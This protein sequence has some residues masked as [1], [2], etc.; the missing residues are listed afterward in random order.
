LFRPEAVAAASAPPGAVL[1]RGTRARALLTTLYALA[2]LALL[3]LLVLG[4][5]TR[6]ATV[7]GVVIPEDG[8]HRVVSASAGMVSAWQVREGQQAKAGE[9]LLQMRSLRSVAGAEN[10]DALISALL[11]QRVQSLQQDQAA[12]QRQYLQRIE[13]ADARATGLAQQ[14]AQLDAQAA[15]QAERSRLA[16]A[17]VERY[18][19][20]LRRGVVAT[21]LLQ[22]QQAAELDQ[23]QRAAELERATLAVAEE[24]RA[25]HAT[26]TDLRWQATREQ[27]ADARSLQ[28]LAQELAESEARSEWVVRAPVS[29]TVS[30]LLLQAGQAAAAG[31]ALATL[32]NA[33]AP[34]GVELYVPSR[35]AG[36]LQAGQEVKLRYR[37]FPFQQ[38]GQFDGRVATVS[39]NALSASELAPEIAVLTAPGTEALYQVRVALAAQSV[40]I[41]GARLPLRPGALVDASIRLE[42]RRLYEWMLYPLEG[43]RGR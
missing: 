12:Q 7:R 20:L 26:T 21:A 10:T 41:P 16:A 27:A 11:R 43:L 37:A 19:E 4:R 22:E 18:R 42:T 24:L 17:N 40:P 1:L 13:A 29:G 28:A 23:Q 5:Y 15:L 34:L 8:V 6:S 9:V 36:R 33:A 30:T 31:Q 39:G 38:Y 32:V 35:A 3:C 2:A 25:A 14:L